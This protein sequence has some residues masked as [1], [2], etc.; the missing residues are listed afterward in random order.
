[1]PDSPTI[2]KTPRDLWKRLTRAEKLAWL[3][4]TNED[5]RLFREEFVMCERVHSTAPEIAQAKALLVAV[6]I[7]TQAR[8]NEV[9][10]FTKP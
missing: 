1:M 10:D 4:S 8:A 5:V 3:N 7:L 6:G 2:A 9:F